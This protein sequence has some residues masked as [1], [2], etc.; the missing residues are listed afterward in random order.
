[1]PKITIFYDEKWYPP[2]FLDFDQVSFIPRLTRFSADILRRGSVSP[3]SCPPFNP[4]SPE[5]VKH[6]KSHLER[7]PEEFP[8]TTVTKDFGLDPVLEVHDVDYIEYL[9]T[10]FHEW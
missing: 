5:R 7:F 2:H 3:K 4:E 1:M 6:I 8:V 9:Q 10:I